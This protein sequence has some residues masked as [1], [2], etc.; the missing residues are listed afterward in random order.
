[1]ALE[2]ARTIPSMLR[3]GW[4]EAAART[5]WKRLGALHD[6]LVPLTAAIVFAACTGAEGVSE[7]ISP[8]GG[9]NELD[10]A[11]VPGAAFVAPTLIPAVTYDGSG[12]LVHPDAAVFP[13]GWQGKRYWIAA[14]P[15]PGGNPKYENP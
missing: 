4:R 1:M 6:A 5:W 12:Q 8:P 15:Y 9:A 3:R 11:E 14:T 10:E 2:Q 13:R 7:P